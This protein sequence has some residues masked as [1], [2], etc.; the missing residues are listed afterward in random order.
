MKYAYGYDPLDQPPVYRPV[1]SFVAVLAAPIAYFSFFAM[2]A[3]LA[4][5]TGDWTGPL[6]VSQRH[7]VYVDE[8]WTYFLPVCSGL[9][10]A[11]VTM[12]GCLI[13]LVRYP[14]PT[15]K[16]SRATTDPSEVTE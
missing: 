6:L 15:R 2:T 7:G 12:F 13:A 5:Y 14:P 10:A 9:V 4:A 3:G 1:I 16:R 8:A 11:T